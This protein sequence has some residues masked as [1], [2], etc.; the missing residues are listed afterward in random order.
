[1]HLTARHGKEFGRKHDEAIA[2]LQ[3]QRNI[4]E[5]ALGRRWRQKAHPLGPAGLL[6]EAVWGL[7]ADH[8]F[9]QT[10]HES[11]TEKVARSLDMGTDEL[12]LCI[13]Q[14]QIGSALL[15]RFGGSG[16]ATDNT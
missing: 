6:C 2:A 11:F 3:P 9:V 13:A 10:G 4:D 14:R 15:D 5:A 16:I 12:R 8:C 1:M 7:P